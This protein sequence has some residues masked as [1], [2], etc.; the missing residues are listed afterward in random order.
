MRSIAEIDKEI[1]EVQERI[2]RR[3]E[4][5]PLKSEPAYRAARFDYI[6]DGDRSGLDAYQNALNAAIQNKLSRDAQ[7]RLV[8][9]GK[10]Q[11]D[12]ENM[13]QWQKDYTFA[14]SAQAEAYA[15]PKSTPRERENADANVRYHEAVGAKKGY[16]KKYAEMTKAPEGEKKPEAPKDETPAAEVK[17]VRGFEQ[18]MGDVD[19]L[20]GME[21]AVD[22]AEIDKLYNELLDYKGNDFTTRETNQA[23]A[24]LNNKK[25]SNADARWNEYNSRVKAALGEKNYGKRKAALE[26]LKEELANYKGQEKY[27]EVEKSIND[28]LKKPSPDALN[29]KVILDNFTDNDAI[30]IK[31][32]LEKKKGDKVIPRVVMA[33]NKDRTVKF[34]LK[35]NGDLIVTNEKGGLLHTWPEKKLES[36]DNGKTPLDE[37]KNNLKNMTE[38]NTSAAIMVRPPNQVANVLKDSTLFPKGRVL[39]TSSEDW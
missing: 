27:A 1:A 35:A 36:W 12:D 39:T 25:K 16:M 13:A 31:G 18:I 29:E 17:P 11:A 10:E 15:N 4:G 2:A 20:T 33:G 30:A 34:K 24:K 28:G 38:Q 5:M 9:L 23:L 14:K 3:N 19:K 37:L 22:P 26:P 7:E 6:V 8:K 32:E 21:G